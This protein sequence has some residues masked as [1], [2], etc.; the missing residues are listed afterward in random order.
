M[1]D[2]GNY[3]DVISITFS[4]PKQAVENDIEI[5]EELIDI[6]EDITLSVDGL[7]V[8]GLMILSSIAHDL[9]YRT[10]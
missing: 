7:N 8:N 2:L 3:Y 4:T 9:C 10:L 5:P 6:Q 1:L